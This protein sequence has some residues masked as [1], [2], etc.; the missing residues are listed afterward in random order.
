MAV[1]D[2]DSRDCCVLHSCYSAKKGTKVP[3][4]CLPRMEDE[5]QEGGG[6]DGGRGRRQPSWEPGRG[7]SS[8]RRLDRRESKGPSGP[9]RMA[10]D[11]SRSS[12]LGSLAGCDVI[13]R[14]LSQVQ[15]R[16]HSKNHTSVSPGVCA[17]QGTHRPGVTPCHYVLL[18]EVREARFCCH[19][20]ETCPGKERRQTNIQTET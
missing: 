3:R 17:H 8:Y 9:S 4:K 12:G 13:H 1:S 11:A 2:S 6:G 7:R 19:S 16:M 20:V 10:A 14:Q 18:L 5:D 15:L